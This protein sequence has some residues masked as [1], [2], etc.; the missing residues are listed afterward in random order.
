MSNKLYSIEE[1]YDNTL[2]KRYDEYMKTK[3]YKEYDDFLT[4]YSRDE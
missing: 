4:E 3:E 2:N 1:F